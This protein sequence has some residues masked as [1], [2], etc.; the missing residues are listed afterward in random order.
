VIRKAI[1]FSACLLLN[2]T[3]AGVAKAE[4]IVVTVEGNGTE[5][6]NQT[7]VQTQSNTSVSQNNDATVNNNVNSDANTGNNDA[8]SNSGDATIATGDTQ[9]TTNVN[10]QN[11]NTNSSDVAGC[12]SAS[13]TITISGNGTGSTNYVLSSNSTT[14]IVNQNNTAHISNNI[15]IKGNTGYNTASFNGGSILISTGDIDANTTVNN[16][17]INNTFYV[18]AVGMGD[19]ILFIKGNG[20]Y[21]LNNAVLLDNVSVIITNDNEANITNNVENDLNTGG[22][23]A[24]MNNGDVAIVTGGIES[25]VTINN[26]N[27]NSSFVQVTCNCEKEKN[28]PVQNPPSSNPPGGSST[29]QG[30]SG[31]S[32][33]SGSSNGSTSGNNL[34]ATGAQIPYTLIATLILFFMFL[35]GLYL[36]FHGANAPPPLA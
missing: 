21:S 8:N 15:Y 33:S 16:K 10:N 11:I 28:P 5:S 17:N 29:V 23:S 13:S 32:G 27:I 25:N 9:S 3:L 26:E 14:N 18:G 35:S 1:L 4:E 30:A 20:A 6:T 7:Q 12:C 24:W 22:N 19:S 36:R 31:N 34:P 2:L